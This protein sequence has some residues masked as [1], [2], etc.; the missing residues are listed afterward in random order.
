[1]FPMLFLRVTINNSTVAAQATVRVRFVTMMTGGS[2]APVLRGHGDAA[3]QN[4]LDQLSRICPRRVGGTPIFV[5]GRD[6]I[7]MVI[8]AALE[9]GLRADG[10]FSISSPN[11]DACKQYC[12]Q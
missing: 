8:M 11:F 5:N 3:I 6:E 7:G 4:A 2:L 12:W 1:M 10:Q 9:S